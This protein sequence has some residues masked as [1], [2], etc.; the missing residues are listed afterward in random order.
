ML[1][2]GFFVFINSHKFVSPLR[3]LVNPLRYFDEVTK[4]E[5]GAK[6]RGYKGKAIPLQAWRGP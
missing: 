2:Y 4:Q 5:L 1:T 3:F 6:D